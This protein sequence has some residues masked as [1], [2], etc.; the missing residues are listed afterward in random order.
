MDSG[1]PQVTMLWP[2][3]FSVYTDDLESEI[4]WRKLEVLV[5]KF[6]DDTKGAKIIRSPEDRD[7]MQTARTAYVTG[8]RPGAWPSTTASA[9]SCM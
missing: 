9:R 6:A 1:D 8:Q 5:K 2:M 7:K 3:L 4:E